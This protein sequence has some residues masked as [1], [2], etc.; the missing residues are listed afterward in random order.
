MSEGQA[1]SNGLPLMKKELNRSTPTRPKQP[2]QEG[3]PDVMGWGLTGAAGGGSTSDDYGSGFT[4]ERL[5]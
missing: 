5:E 1:P 2:A 3:R 4:P